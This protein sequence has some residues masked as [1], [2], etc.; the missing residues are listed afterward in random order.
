MAAADLDK[1]ARK[2][3]ERLIHTK[4]TM[5]LSFANCFAILKLALVLLHLVIGEFACDHRHFI[6]QPGIDAEYSSLVLD[7]SV[8]ASDKFHGIFLPNIATCRAG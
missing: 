4:G 8:H 2:G 6:D 1:R 7:I 3:C 5:E